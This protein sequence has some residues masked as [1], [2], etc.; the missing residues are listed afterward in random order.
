MNT[1]F[2]NARILSGSEIIEG[3]LGVAGN[4]IAFVGDVP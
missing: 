4:M 1:L 2:K 3:C